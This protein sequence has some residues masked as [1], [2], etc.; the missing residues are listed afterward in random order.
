M[1]YVERPRWILLKSLH[2]EPVELQSFL[3][4]QLLKPPNVRKASSTSLVTGGQGRKPGVPF[5]V[6]ESRL[7]NAPLWFRPVIE[8]PTSAL[9]PRETQAGPNTR[10]P[11]S[12][13]YVETRQED[14][15]RFDA[16]GRAANRVGPGWKVSHLEARSR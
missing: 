2:P 12:A 3:T 6:L 10:C 1:P 16:C 11:H 8:R 7:K 9:R 13:R 14:A 4:G 15:S 5:D